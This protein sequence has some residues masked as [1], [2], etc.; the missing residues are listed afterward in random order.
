[1]KTYQTLLFDV[2]DTLLDFAAAEDAAFRKL[3]LEQGFTYNDAWKQD[4]R[5]MN[6]ELWS[7]YERGEM[8]RDEVVNTRFSK[9]FQKLGKEVD[10]RLLENSYRLYLEDGN[11]LLDGALAL[12]KEL[13]HHYE[14]YIVTNGFSKTQDKR[15]KASGLFPFFKGVFVSEDTGFQKPMR[16]FF[17]CCFASIPNLDVQTALIIGDSLSA[18]IQGGINVGMDT[19]WI[20]PSRKENVSAIQPTYEIHHLNELLELLKIKSQS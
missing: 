3:L 2:D 14:M 9:F 19:C 8:S 18:D 1:M 17:D 6:Q 10:G 12:V 7:A 4:Y 16:E 20:N 15:L 13:S 11:Q 5:L